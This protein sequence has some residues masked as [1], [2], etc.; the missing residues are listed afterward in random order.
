MRK[1]VGKSQ[2]TLGT[3]LEQTASEVLTVLYKHG[4]RRREVDAVFELA[5]SELNSQPV[6]EPIAYPDSQ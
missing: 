1:K 6:Q 3:V 5:I 4:I 2:Y